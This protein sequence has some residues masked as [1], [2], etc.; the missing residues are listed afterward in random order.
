ML[1]I[2]V[3]VRLS[4]DDIRTWFLLLSYYLQETF[5]QD[6]IYVHFLRCTDIR[7][8]DRSLFFH[9]GVLGIHVRRYLF[10]ETCTAP[11]LLMYFVADSD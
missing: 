1:N 3:G 6:S 5:L 4:H 10:P 7:L 11:R 8:A 2:Y 9:G